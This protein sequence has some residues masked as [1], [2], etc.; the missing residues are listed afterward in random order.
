MRLT[1]VTFC[2]IF[3]FLFQSYLAAQQTKFTVIAVSG[4][5]SLRISA[6]DNFK[7]IV[8]GSKISE[9]DIKLSGNAYLALV[10]T[11]GKSFEFK[12]EGLYKTTDI[13]KMIL[14]NNVSSSRKLVNYLADKITSTAADSKE[15]KLLGAVV[16]TKLGT[17]ELA[18]P[19]ESS[20]FDTT[21]TF[22]WFGNKGTKNYI[23]RLINSHNHTVYMQEIKDTAFTLNLQELNLEK[24]TRYK[25][26][27]YSNGDE[28]VCSDTAGFL[29]IDD[30]QKRFLYDSLSTVISDKEASPSAIGALLTARFFEEY[31][32]Q[33][34]ADKYY[35]KGVFLAPTVKEYSLNYVNFL[36]SAGMERKAIMVLNQFHKEQSK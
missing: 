18:S 11:N 10:H 17:I 5:V 34:E 19:N 21:V 23:F 3:L 20:V 4:E 9:G 1:K 22:R 28:N 32:F 12:K 2:F 25:W 8:T 24:S 30:L 13:E 6:N 14:P 16:R 33:Y 15:M 7:P 27:L 35:S 29:V 26:F 31:K 36:I